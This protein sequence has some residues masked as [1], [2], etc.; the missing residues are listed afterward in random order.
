MRSDVAYVVVEL[1]RIGRELVAGSWSRGAR[2]ITAIKAI[3]V[4]A[5]A[6][7]VVVAGGL[8]AVVADA[9]ERLD[10]VDVGGSK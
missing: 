3:A 2:P 5:E 6:A 10:G 9:R 1:R 7:K 4:M 8:A